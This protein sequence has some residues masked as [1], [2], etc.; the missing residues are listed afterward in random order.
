M[1]ILVI[2]CGSSSLKYK[3]FDM[4][5]DS[6]IAEGRVERIGENDG[7][8]THQA[9]DREKVNKTKPIPEH[10]VAISECLSLL[11]DPEVGAIESLNDIKGIGHRVLH[12]G[13][14]FKQSTLVDD[15]ALDQMEEL[16]DL[17]PCICPPISWV[18]APA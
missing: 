11:T 8:I 17:G 18:S 12:G 16:R 3:L 5:K 9:V 6:V 13:E 7:I 1:K 15:T 14:Y 4:D 10:S 2:N